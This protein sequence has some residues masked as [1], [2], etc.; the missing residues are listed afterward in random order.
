MLG[1]II[2]V[3]DAIRANKILK[4][5][6]NNQDILLP[7]EL[8][9]ID[10]KYLEEDYKNAI[11]TKNR[12]EDKAKTII[13][14]LTISITLILNLSKIIEAISE[15]YQIQSINILIFVLALLA[16]VYML[17]AGMI[18]IQVLIKENIFYPIPLIERSKNDKSIVYKTTQLNIN[19]NLIRNNIIYASYRSI[20]NSAICLVI[21][22][23]LAIL[24]FQNVDKSNNVYG[25]QNT[26][27]DVS[28][29]VDAM[30]WLVE[31]KNKNISFEEIV[32]TYAKGNKKMP[33]KNIYDKE[34]KIVITIKKVEDVY[35]IDNIIN[36]IEEMK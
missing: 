7:E 13:A 1:E 11:D 35:V 4:E 29:S 22:F 26:D 31:N 30:N 36:D 20:R 34:N 16:I 19:Q 33:I 27:E 14:A 23:I 8:E 28:F 15:K 18:S 9:D 6:N 2:P 25:N 21:I 32:H 10:I 17:M 3:I 5:K 12:L 24:P